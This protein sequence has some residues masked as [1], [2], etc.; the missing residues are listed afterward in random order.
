MQYL[1]DL[2]VEDRLVTTFSLSSF[3]E[4]SCESS[5]SKCLEIVVQCLSE[6]LL[7]YL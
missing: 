2:Q 6:K 7:D 4:I 1:R 5:Y 3:S